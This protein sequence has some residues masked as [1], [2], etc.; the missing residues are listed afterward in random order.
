MSAFEEVEKGL[1]A[2][3]E[4]TEE[5][6]KHLRVAIERQAEAASALLVVA[7]ASRDSVDAGCARSAERRR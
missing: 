3:V 1:H 4:K 2:A 7:Q 6:R 5:G